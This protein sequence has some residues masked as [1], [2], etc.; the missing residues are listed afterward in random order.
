MLP[1]E[2]LVYSVDFGYSV[3][4]ILHQIEK[5]QQ[6]VCAATDR[7]LLEMMIFPLTSNVY[8]MADYI[9]LLCKLSL[10]AHSKYIWATC[11]KMVGRAPKT[12]WKNGGQSR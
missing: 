6:I 4:R 2:A 7:C 8:A 11:R 1:V 12:R 9:R 3:N 10:N 5:A